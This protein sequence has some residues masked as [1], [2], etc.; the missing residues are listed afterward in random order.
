MKRDIINA[1]SKIDGYIDFSDYKIEI[2]NYK[3]PI[4]IIDNE[5]DI[6]LIN[7][8]DECMITKLYNDYYLTIAEIACLYDIKYYKMNNKIKELGIERNRQNRRNSSYGAVFTEER[9]RHM[10]ESQKGKTPV[11]YVRTKE[12]REKISKTL[13]EGYRTG[14]IKQDASKKS[15]AWADGKYKNAKMGR[16]IQGFFYSKKMNKDMYFRSLLE[17]KFMIGVENSEKVITYDFE[18]MQI[19][20]PHNAHYTPDAI[21]N[22]KY[23]VELKPYDHLKYTDRRRFYLELACANDYCNKNKM[24]YLLVYDKDIG[25]KSKEYRKYLK[26]NPDIIRQYNI[27]F[28]K[29]L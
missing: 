20:L 7:N 16:G 27:R 1:S 14:R 2:H 18:P 6:K 12:I 13:K 29:E 25:F 19:K 10:S 24:I 5:E 28:K 3:K 22:E 26:D 23:I 15:K 11:G 4:L 9:L 21:I 8:K 17:L